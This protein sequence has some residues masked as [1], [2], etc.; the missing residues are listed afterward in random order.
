MS[1]RIRRA[2]RDV[3]PA[4]KAL[5]YVGGPL[6]L[7]AWGFAHELADT[8][9]LGQ[10]TDTTGLTVILSSIAVLYG[11]WRAVGHHPLLPG[12]KKWLELSP[13][14]PGQRLPLGP[15]RLVP[16]DLVVLGVILAPVALPAAKLPL[17]VGVMPVVLGGLQAFL[18]AYAL[19]L[20]VT[21]M[22][23]E[24][25]RLAYPLA[26]GAGAWLV[27]RDPLAGVAI[28]AAMAAWT[29]LGLSASLGGFPW[30]EETDPK[31]DLGEVYPYA[32]L[33][34]D[35]DYVKVRWYDGLALA[36]LGGWW[37]Y[38]LCSLEG[39]EPAAVVMVGAVAAFIRLAVYLN[40]TAAPI[41]LLG[42]L[43]TLR[44][45][46]PGYDVA[47]LAPALALVACIGVLLGSEGLGW[48]GPLRGAVSVGA[49]LLIVFN[50]GPS[51]KTWRLT[52]YHR[53]AEPNQAQRLQQQQQQQRQ[54]Q[55]QKQAF[56]VA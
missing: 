2:F 15:V 25:A 43:R 49:T 44:P 9:R 27:F 33:K 12:Y 23:T 50:L 1:G 42:R 3:L 26:F 11:L 37:T 52:G 39:M 35:T 17:T 56:R 13:W 32:Q 6:W 5:A 29:Q 28:A 34:H 55:Q 8:V 24:V 19:C 41:S 36:S 46:I 51:L 18:L 54:Q 47:W 7:L 14:A 21:F 10:R 38:V 53:I 31:L 30:R 22:L 48:S 40:G 20:G 45:V 16:Q 4:R